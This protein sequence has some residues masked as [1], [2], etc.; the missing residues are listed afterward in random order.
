M[1]NFMMDHGMIISRLD[2]QQEEIIA[3]VDLNEIRCVTCEFFVWGTTVNFDHY[4]Q[5]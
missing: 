5:T 3:A 1:L 4:I 2:C